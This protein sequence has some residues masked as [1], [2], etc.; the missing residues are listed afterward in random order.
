M[1]QCLMH[2]RR[3]PFVKHQI[4][5][6]PGDRHVKP[7]WDRPASNPPVPVP[8]ATKNRNEGENHQRQGHK[9]QKNV[10]GQHREVN[11]GEPA[12]VSRR[13]LAN[14][15]MISDVAHQKTDRRRQ[16]CDHAHH[17]TTPRAAPDEIPAHGNE[18]GAHEITRG[19]H[20]RQIGG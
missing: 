5:E 1:L 16:G 6:H 20:G 15:R 2:A 7:D 4:H 8:S 9:C 14:L 11:R 13:F 10:R 19:I 17:V 18:A 3:E 12:S